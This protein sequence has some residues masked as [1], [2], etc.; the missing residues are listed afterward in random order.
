MKY[1][2]IIKCT[3]KSKY[4]SNDIYPN[5]FLLIQDINELDS[6]MNIDL[7]GD[8]FF[9]TDFSLDEVELI[10][11]I[12]SLQELYDFCNENNIEIDESLIYEKGLLA[13]GGRDYFIFNN[14]TPYGWLECDFLFE[15][16]KR[17]KEILDKLSIENEEE[18]IE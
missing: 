4:Y 15:T 5:S 1:N 8:F 18:I 9:N 6:D 14:L 10:K 7:S 17:K 13:G 12:G 3:M 2:K 16:E 11:E